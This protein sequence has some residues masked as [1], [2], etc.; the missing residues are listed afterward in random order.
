[1]PQSP[2]FSL[3]PPPLLHT[4]ILRPFSFSPALSFL[5]IFIYLAQSLLD[6]S[7]QLPVEYQLSQLTL[8]STPK[9]EEFPDDG[10]L[11]SHSLST[12]FS[13]AFPIT[14]H[15]LSRFLAF[16]RYCF[17]AFSRYRFLFSFP[18]DGPS[19]LTSICLVYF[20]SSF[21]RKYSSIPT[22]RNNCASGPAPHWQCPRHGQFTTKCKVM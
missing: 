2:S 20:H 12:R 11:L 17:L 4:L 22:T 13:A 10:S 8:T 6:N 18:L 1:M 3:L 5:F 7:A 21:S 16:S 15:S 14:I 9:K 19:F